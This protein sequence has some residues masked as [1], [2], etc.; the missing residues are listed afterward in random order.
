M[1]TLLVG[2]LAVTLVG[3][4]C[5]VSPQAGVEAC[6]GAVGG[7][8]CFDRTA[9]GQAIEPKPRSLDADSTTPRTR[10]R[11]AAR[12]EKRLRLTPAIKPTSP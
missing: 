7:F 12:T 2:A 5:F 9:V 8:A 4:S 1:R 6:T 3:C 10:S 11:I